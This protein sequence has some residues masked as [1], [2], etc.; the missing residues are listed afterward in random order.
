MVFEHFEHTHK[1]H[2]MFKHTQTIRQLLPTNFFSVFYQ[3][4]GLALKVSMTN[5]GE[6]L[7]SHSSFLAPIEDL[8]IVYEF[9]IWYKV[10]LSE[11][12]FNFYS[13]EIIRSPIIFWCFQRGQNTAQ[14]MK[15][16]IKDFC[17]KCD[18]IRRKLRIWSH[19]L[20]KS[21]IE[22]FIFCAVEVN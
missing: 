3:F 4:V 15:F 13:L 21:L 11:L 12:I 16:S 5:I 1:S 7:S 10:N 22:N 19:L 6:S 8:E 9:S 20:R 14:K 17:S 18:L 2:K